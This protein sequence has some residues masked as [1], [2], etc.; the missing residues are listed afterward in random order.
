MGRLRGQ[1]HTVALSGE[2]SVEEPTVAAPENSSVGESQSD[3]KAE[4]TVQKYEDQFRTLKSATESKLSTPEVGYRIF[5]TH[6][7]MDWLVEY[8]AALLSKYSVGDDG[9][10]AYERLHGKKPHEH[11]VELGEKVMYYIPKARRV[12]MDRR[13]GIG[14]FLGKALWGDDHFISRADGTMVKARGLA[15]M[16]PGN[17]WD[18][19]MCWSCSALAGVHL[20][21]R[22]RAP[23]AQSRSPNHQCLYSQVEDRL[24]GDLAVMCYSQNKSHMDVME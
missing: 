3:G 14:I 9:K 1:M 5:S 21:W 15:R 7:S 19:T 10:P 2:T 13:F 22:G 4:R 12:K 23:L 11:V 20:H 16:P 24:F 6:A 8:R 17:R 18:A